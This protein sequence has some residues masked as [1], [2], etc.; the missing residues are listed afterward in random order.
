[1]KKKK[2]LLLV[3]IA[4]V[5]LLSATAA[6][7]FSGKANAARLSAGE[8]VNHH[9][10]EFTKDDFSG[11]FDETEGYENYYNMECSKVKGIGGLYD[12]VSELDTTY[13]YAEKQENFSFNDYDD[14]VFTISGAS[15]WG[16]SIQFGIIDRAE[17]ILADSYLKVEINGVYQSARVFDSSG[18]YGGKNYFTAYLNNHNENETVKLLGAVFVFEC[19]K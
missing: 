15:Y 10:I 12:I 1:M 14:A 5:A 11:S 17:P 18:S 13:A 16:I 9:E 8:E 2:I 19:A 7:V 4:S 3:S 6:V